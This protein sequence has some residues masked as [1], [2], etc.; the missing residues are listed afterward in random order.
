MGR[1]FL[2]RRSCVLGANPPEVLHRP[3]T[4][5][6][7]KVLGSLPENVR[8]WDRED[9]IGV[10]E[11]WTHIGLSQIGTLANRPLCHKRFLSPGWP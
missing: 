6:H 8:Q 3:K 4:R 7:C 11:N 2:S 10:V 1:L 9:L 5:L